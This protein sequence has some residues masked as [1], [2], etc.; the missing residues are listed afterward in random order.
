MFPFNYL[1]LF[2]LCDKLVWKK[3][4]SLYKQKTHFPQIHHGKRN[5]DVCFKSEKSQ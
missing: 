3:I 5:V 4:H 1:V 2:K